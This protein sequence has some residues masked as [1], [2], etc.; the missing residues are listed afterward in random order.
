MNYEAW[1]ATYQ[2]SEQAAQAAFEDA[3]KHHETLLNTLT[4]CNELDANLQCIIEA[5]TAEGPGP[6]T[7]AAIKEMP[8][9]SLTQHVAAKQVEALNSV[10][11]YCQGVLMQTLGQELTGDDVLRIVE[12]QVQQRQPVNEN[13]LRNTLEF[14]PF[15]V[16]I[17]GLQADL[18]TV[19]EREQTLAAHLKRIQSIGSLL[20]RNL[21]EC[22]NLEDMCDLIE[23][24]KSAID[25]GPANSSELLQHAEALE[26]AAGEVV[27]AM[28]KMANW[29]LA[30]ADEKR[31]QANGGGQ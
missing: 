17:A 4:R 5:A 31:R 24:W 7:Q 26:E 2:S 12:Q 11:M 27:P 19:I 22:G 13:E 8:P 6:L 15:R 21:D 1:R 14:E 23:K 3:R 30:R 28:H 20:V 16:V 18:D 25:E 10:L 9:H 29:L